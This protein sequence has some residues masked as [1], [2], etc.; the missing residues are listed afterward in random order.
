MSG[1]TNLFATE[2]RYHPECLKKYICIKDNGK[3][4]PYQN[5]YVEEAKQS[6]LKYI[7]KVIFEENEPRTLKGL[8]HEYNNIL[9]NHNFPIFNNYKNDASERIR[10]KYR[11]S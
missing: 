2:I 6:L 1:C 4:S 9:M 11:L 7:S 3:Q 10:W 8:L 5:D